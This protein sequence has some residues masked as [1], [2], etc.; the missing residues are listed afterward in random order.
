M[1]KTVNITLVVKYKNKQT[2]TKQKNKLINKQQKPS[3]KKK[4]L[5]EASDQAAFVSSIKIKICS[6]TVPQVIT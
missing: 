2:N 5:L 1:V 3:K 6:I 4:K